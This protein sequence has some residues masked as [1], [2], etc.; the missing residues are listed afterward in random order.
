[1]PEETQNLEI[2]LQELEALVKGLTDE[3]LDLKAIIWNL[4]KE[5]K[6]APVIREVPISDENRPSPVLPIITATPIV[7][8]HS[9]ET[10]P[11]S[12]SQ[13]PSS[14][15]D[16]KKSEKK[17]DNIV[18]KMQP[19]GTLRPT[20]ENGEDIIVASVFDSRGKDG[21]KKKQMDDII[22]ADE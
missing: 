19:D 10:V 18:L 21:N 1:M 5:N 6:T 15:P 4:Q 11:N 20:E 8:N 22:V 7:T 3:V 17:E 9:D 2:R 12:S 16:S 14:S 13:N